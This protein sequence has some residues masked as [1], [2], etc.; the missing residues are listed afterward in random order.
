MEIRV[1]SVD[2]CI[3]KHKVQHLTCLVYIRMLVEPLGTHCDSRA[4]WR[5]YGDQTPRRRVRRKG[6]GETGTQQVGVRMGFSMSFFF[7]CPCL[8]K[9]LVIYAF[10]TCRFSG[11]GGGG[12]VRFVP[13]HF[14]FYI[15]MH[16]TRRH[17]PFEFRENKL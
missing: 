1:I 13:C 14:I 5:R 6:S 7:K 15:L 2:L 9:S 16:I 10:V 17:V 11:G 8:M 3:M 4:Y 12:G